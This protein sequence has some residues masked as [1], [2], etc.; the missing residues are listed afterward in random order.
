VYVGHLAVAL[1]AKRVRREVP[2]LVLLLA[3]QG[4]DWIQLAT[5]PIEGYREAQLHTHSIPA[6]LA[7]ALLVAIAWG[8]ASRDWKGALLVSVV[9]ATHL[10]LDFV[11]GAKLWWPGRPAWGACLY[12]QPELDF[13]FESLMVVAGWLVYR[14]VLGARRSA[15]LAWLM[16]A[17][18]IT[19]QAAVDTVELVRRMRAPAIREK[20]RDELAG[21]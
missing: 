2:L 1:G 18:L 19:C 9:Y 6:I 21:N 5:T 4:P 16:L 7:G 12:E 17:M 10:P 14:T 11:T 8:V 15:R 3:S 20:C 13:V